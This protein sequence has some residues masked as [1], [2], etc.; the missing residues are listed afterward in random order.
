[1]R[2]KYLTLNEIQKELLQSLKC[3][4]DFCS[5]HKLR[6][7]LDAGSLL[8]Y[9]R[10]GGFIPWDDDIDIV[11]PRKD[12]DY[13]YHNFNMVD[14]YIASIEND[15]FFCYPFC[16]I[17][18]IKNKKH[19]KGWN[20]RKDYNVFIDVFPLD[21]TTTSEMDFKKTNEYNRTIVD[22]MYLTLCENW[23]FELVNHS[24]RKNSKFWFFIF[25]YLLSL[26]FFYKI[27]GFRKLIKKFKKFKYESTN[28]IT[29]S[30]FTDK[31]FDNNFLA[32]E[33][34]DLETVYFSG[35]KSKI[36]KNY[37]RYLTIFYG[38]YMILPPLHEQTPKHHACTKNKK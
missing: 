16:R 15:R 11:M 25:W 12:Y 30:L 24:K 7:S 4:D 38:D 36:I 10:H 34:D 19:I 9:V 31:S 13:F 8:G 17:V 26:T 22:L 33:F 3:F 27:F 32:N 18:S 6:Y 2:S 28:H 37:H 29:W 14:F 1:M 23:I 20:R 21:F 5:L 35:V